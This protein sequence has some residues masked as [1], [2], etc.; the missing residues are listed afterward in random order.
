VLQD[1]IITFTPGL[2]ELGEKLIE[3]KKL[4]ESKQ[5]FINTI[6]PHTLVA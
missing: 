1:V 4:R 2:S 3:N 6:R 5:A